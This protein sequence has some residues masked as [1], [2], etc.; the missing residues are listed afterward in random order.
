[1][2]GWWEQD[3]KPPAWWPHAPLAL[4]PAARSLVR[5]SDELRWDDEL[6]INRPLDRRLWALWRRVYWS[7]Y[8]ATGMLPEPL[9]ME[10]LEGELRACFRAIGA[11]QA[12]ADEVTLDRLG[13]AM[14]RL[15][16]VEAIWARWDAVKD[17]SG[18]SRT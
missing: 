11:M 5:A 2:S 9:T 18:V 1:M 15:Q 7:R 3:D 4:A 8:P 14:E 13:R 10:E 16:D 17:G 6:V 12:Q